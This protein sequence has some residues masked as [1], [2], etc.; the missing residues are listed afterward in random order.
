M[1]R[2]ARKK[3]YDYTVIVEAIAELLKFVTPIVVI[4][5]LV[6]FGLRTIYGAINGGKIK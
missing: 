1:R 6:G 5:A 4:F 2:G 3:M